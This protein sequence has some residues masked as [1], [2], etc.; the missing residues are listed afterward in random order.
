MNTEVSTDNIISQIEDEM[1]PRVERA[2]EYFAARLRE[3]LPKAGDILPSKRISAAT[4]RTAAKISVRVSKKSHD[5]LERIVNIPFPWNF[6]EFGTAHESANPVG[7]RTLVAEYDK[8][9]AILAG[10]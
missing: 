4:G 10:E 9:S 7:R 3:N 6:H 8:I 5:R 1:E 2:A